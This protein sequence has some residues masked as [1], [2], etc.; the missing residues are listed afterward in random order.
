MPEIGALPSTPSINRPKLTMLKSVVGGGLS[1]DYCYSRSPS[2]HGSNIC[3]LFLW[4]TNTLTKPINRVSVG[5]ILVC[6]R[7][8]FLLFLVWWWRQVWIDPFPWRTNHSCWCYCWV[9]DE[10]SV[11]FCYNSFEIWNNVSLQS[12]LIFFRTDQGTFNVTLTPNIGDLIRPAP[13]TEQEFIAEESKIVLYIKF[14]EKLTGMH[15]SSDSFS[16]D[17]SDLRALSQKVLECIYT[18][19]ITLDTENGKFRFSSTTNI[20][21]LPLLIT[22]DADKQGQKI[23]LGVLS[24]STVLNSMLLKQLKQSLGN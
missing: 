24:E 18:S 8:E 9:S 3:G 2:M 17:L 22:L 13:L 14:L 10:H 15:A 7:N 16:L 19:P 12:T 23:K 5:K 21:G 6:F 11:W 4:L 1:I 20:E